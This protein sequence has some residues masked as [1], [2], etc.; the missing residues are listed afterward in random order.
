MLTLE[1]MGLSF[2]RRVLFE[3][4]ELH[5]PKGETFGIIGPG[6]VGKTVL[7]KTIS[8]LLK[9]DQGTLSVLAERQTMTF[10]RSGL[11][12]SF[13]AEDNLYFVL[14]EKGVHRREQFP[15]VEK[16]LGEVG[17]HEQRKLFPHE[18]SGGMQKRL[19]IARALLLEPELILYDDPTAGLDPVTAR[20]ITDLIVAMKKKYSMT[21]LLTASDLRVIYNLS[22]RVGFLYDGK[23]IETGTPHEIQNSPNPIVRQFVQGIIE[24][25]LGESQ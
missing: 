9:P 25:P 8:G 15:R 12:D 5:V 16:A 17:L 14:D 18:M 24:G 22:D 11:F 1:N 7:L 19:G 13:T 23:F 4:L 21:V 3:N 6:G 2:Q 10:Q 20:T